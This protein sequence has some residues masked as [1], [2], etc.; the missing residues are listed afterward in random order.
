MDRR[1]FLNASVMA[2]LMGSV[3]SDRTLA[4]AMQQAPAG[5]APAATPPTPRPLM[6]D[7]YSRYFHW[8]RN[9][10]EVAEAT[11]EITCGGIMPTVGMAGNA[12]VDVTKV[13]TELPTFVNTMK[14]HGL[15]VRQVRGGGQTAVDAGIETL[16]GTMGQLGVTHY[17]LGTDNYD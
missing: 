17:W 8:L 4:R 1:E 7:A 5:A 11:I 16:V 13:Q 9:L 6:L 10:D 15:K 12:H 3:L 2:T 14:K